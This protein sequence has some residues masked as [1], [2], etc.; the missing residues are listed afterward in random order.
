MDFKEMGPVPYAWVGIA[1]VITMILAVTI[2]LLG[3]PS[4]D[5]N[6]GS[7]CDFGIS[8]VKYV[9]VT[10]IGG[11]ILSGLMFMVSGFGWFMFGESKYVRAGAIVVVISGVA[12]MCVGIFDKTYSFHQYVSIIYAIIFIIAIAL[13]SVQD[14]KDRHFILLI[15]L[16][17]LG[18]FGLATI[19]VDLC[20][21]S[22]VQTIL[23]G[24]VFIW[25][26]FKMLKIMDVQNPIVRKIAGMD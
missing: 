17:I 22:M 21:Y 10:F 13:V 9:S 7:M 1:A 14:I 15:G 25:Y 2:C 23:M 3:D 12:L 20:P 24:Y 5:Y 18:L 16:G 8:D 6:S 4:W 26:D 19:F 11:C